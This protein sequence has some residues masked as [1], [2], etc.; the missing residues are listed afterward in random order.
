MATP[1]DVSFHH[2]IR[3]PISGGPNLHVIEHVLFSPNDDWYLFGVVFCLLVPFNEKASGQYRETE[4]HVSLTPVA[5]QRFEADKFTLGCHLTEELREGRIDVRK[6]PRFQIENYSTKTR[7]GSVGI[8][9]DDYLRF[10]QVLTDLG[11]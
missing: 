5:V 8:C 6:N 4:L 7:E 10:V 9:K 1:K 3:I 11:F 2:I